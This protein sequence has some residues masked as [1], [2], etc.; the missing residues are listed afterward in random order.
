MNR[1]PLPRLLA[2]AALVAS[3]SAC[4]FHLRNALQLPPDLGPVR[5]VSVDPYSPLADSL[6]R[7]LDQVEGAVEVGTANAAEAIANGVD[8]TTAGANEGV[9]VLDILAERWGDTPIAVDQ[10]G[11]SQEFTL[12]YATVFVLRGP[13]GKEVVPQQAIELSRDYLSIPN[14]SLGTDSERELLVKEL[15]REMSAAILRRIDG[16]LSAHGRRQ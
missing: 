2:V 8:P 12:R 9:A 13:D 10:F 1:T 16:A 15:R 5:V 4:G 6:K 11:R 14:Q 3:L 7:S